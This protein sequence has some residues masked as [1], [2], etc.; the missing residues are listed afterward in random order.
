MYEK[1]LM[2]H[3]CLKKENFYSNQ[4][5]KDITDADCYHVKRFVKIFK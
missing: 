3:H 4:N 2:K 1:C 5:M